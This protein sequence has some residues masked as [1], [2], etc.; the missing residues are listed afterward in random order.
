MALKDNNN[1][2]IYPTGSYGGEVLDKLLTLTYNDNDTYRHGLIH[3]QTGVKYKLTLP[4]ATMGKVIQDAAATPT[5]ESGRAGE[6]GFNTVTITERFLQPNHFG[7][8]QIWQPE[9]MASYWKEFSPIK[10]QL[11]R[12][13]D[14]V[15]QA[16][17]L[18]LLTQ[19][20]NEEIGEAIW[21]GVRDGV[22]AMTGYTPVEGL[23]KIG[24][25]DPTQPAAKGNTYFDG[26]IARILKSMKSTNAVDKVNIT[27]SEKLETGEAVEIALKA[28]Y[29]QVKDSLRS[30]TRHMKFVVSWTTWLL[31]DEYLTEHGVVKYTDNTKENTRL[32]R[33]IEIL[34]I[35]GCPDHTIVL[36]KFTKNQDSNLWMAIDWANP[37]DEEVMSMDRLY[38]FSSEWFVK[39]TF[40]C[41]VNI[42]KPSEMYAH[43]AYASGMA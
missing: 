25:V 5:I 33:G 20:K 31:Y 26:V 43:T 27:G 1:T 7:I 3:V 32:F 28:M 24:S 30:Q 18:N 40:K 14:P 2:I 19:T 6:G 12:E 17:F 4:L 23:A 29:K 16:D 38:A 8:F 39:M 10:N 42:V 35:H 34:P 21:M 9:V 15:V 37:K 41:D 36:S 13:L 11:F 22:E